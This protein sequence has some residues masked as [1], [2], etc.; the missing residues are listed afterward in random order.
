MKIYTKA[1]KRS[2]IRSLVDDGI[3]AVPE[4]SA[5]LFVRVAEGMQVAWREQIPALIASF[6]GAESP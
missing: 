3:F 5:S 6:A 1:H 4:L 2:R